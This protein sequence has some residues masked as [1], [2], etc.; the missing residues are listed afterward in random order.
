[1]TDKSKKEETQV[2]GIKRYLK[3]TMDREMLFSL[4]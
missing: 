4:E 1:M 2:R 3:H